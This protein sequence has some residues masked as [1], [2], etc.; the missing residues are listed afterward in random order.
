MARPGSGWF[1]L[2]SLALAIGFW[3]A[4][5][6][7]MPLVTRQVVP[8]DHFATLI[9]VAIYVCAVCGFGFLARAVGGKPV[10]DLLNHGANMEH[11]AAR[12]LYNLLAM[13]L[14]VL[15]LGICMGIPGIEFERAGLVPSP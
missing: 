10:T 6:A 7:V 5:F 15:V 4:T 8:R 3:A 9:G 2:Y 12:L 14:L 1:R 11:P 13:L